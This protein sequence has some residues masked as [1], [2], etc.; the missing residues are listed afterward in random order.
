MKKFILAALVF[1]FGISNLNA[2]KDII[3]PPGTSKAKMRYI[4]DVYWVA[5]TIIK[6]IGMVQTYTGLSKEEIMKKIKDAEERAMQ[7]YN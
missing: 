6:N 5:D 3:V 1:V 4:E 2:S 7:S